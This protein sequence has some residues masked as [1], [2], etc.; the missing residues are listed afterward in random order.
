MF[1]YHAIPINVRHFL[2][3]PVQVLITSYQGRP[4]HQPALSS[5]NPS[6]ILKEGSPHSQWLHLS[7]SVMTM[8][9]VLLLS[10]SFRLRK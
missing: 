4:M 9:A 3:N 7:A 8:E 1:S 6:I 2:P 10:Q 5:A